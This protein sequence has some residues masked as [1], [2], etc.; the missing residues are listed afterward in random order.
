MKVVISV[1]GSVIAPTLSQEK[2]LEDAEVIK[3]LAKDNT[4]LIV[5]GGGK[6]A[7]DYIRAARSMGVSEA[8]CDLIGIALSARQCSII[9]LGIV[10][11]GVSGHSARLSRS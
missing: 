4:L 1:G 3:E 8:V 7:R 9:D 5:T 2:F 6:A 10:E 11:R